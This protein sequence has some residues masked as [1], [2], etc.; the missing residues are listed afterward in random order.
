MFLIKKHLDKS[1]VEIGR[2][3]GGKD[4]TTVINAIKRIESQRLKDPDLSSDIE[5][6]ETSIHNIT[7][8]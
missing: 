1:L 2:A 6:L 4:H 3:F 5:D 8:L 7:G